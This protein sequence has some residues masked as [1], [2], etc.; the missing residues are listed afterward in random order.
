[1]T[2]IYQIPDLGSKGTPVLSTAY[3]TAENNYKVYLY[4]VPYR[5]D[6]QYPNRTSAMYIIQDSIGQTEPIYE[7]RCV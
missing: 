3:A 4:V 1:M 2:E 5:P 6:G 7:K